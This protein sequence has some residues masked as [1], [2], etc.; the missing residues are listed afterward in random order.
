[1]N[2]RCLSELLLEQK[3][4]IAWITLNRPNKCNALNTTLSMALTTA[5]HSLAKDVAV[6]VLRGNGRHF[7]T[8]SDLTDLNHADR[9]A[10]EH[11][12]RLEIGACHA[13]AALPQLTVAIVHGKCYGGGALLPLYCDLRIGLSGVEFALPEVALGW[14]PPFGIERLLANTHRTFALEMLLSG[15][16]CGDKEALEMGW[17]HRL[18]AAEDAGSSYLDMLAGIPRQTL[19]DTRAL[20]IARDLQQMCEADDKAF[21]AFLNHFDTDQARSMIAS[22]VERKRS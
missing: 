11:V 4:S 18:L 14:V 15:R 6:V 10:A 12:I 1:M 8:G 3:G 9:C 7:C 16:V 20:T 17:I 21:A 2:T 22:F 13:L 19:A 5:C